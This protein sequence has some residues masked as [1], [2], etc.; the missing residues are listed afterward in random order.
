MLLYDDSVPN[1]H[2]LTDENLPAS[3]VVGLLC[4]SPDLGSRLLRICGSRMSFG[5]SAKNHSMIASSPMVSQ[6]VTN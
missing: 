3:V 2:Q 4:P 6:L 5:K 1:M